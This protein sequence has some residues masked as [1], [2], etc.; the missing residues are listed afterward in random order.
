MEQLRRDLR[1]LKAYAAVSTLALAG[2]AGAAF[3][4]SSIP[5]QKFDEI[6]VERIN[7]VEKDGRVRLV[8][9]NSA[10]QA[11]TLVD[12]KVILP[13]R[14]RDA[15]LIFFNDEGD[16]DGGMTWSG[17]TENGSPRANAGLSFDQYKQDETVTLRYSQSG[18]DREAGLTIADRPET[19]I[20]AAAALN[21]AK[22]DEERARIRQKLVDAGAVGSRK[23]VFAGKDSGGT[24]KVALSDGTGTPRLVL[25]VEKDGAAKIEFLD[26]AGKV[27][28]TINPE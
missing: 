15:G 18:K 5:R 19:S 16:E 9:A 17:R 12:G 13:N 20:A 1:F 8:I 26:K 24:A 6:D 23:R 14:K 10:R 27:T 28:R 4:Q 7:V 25:S 21:D 2:L 11:A 22:T 3:R